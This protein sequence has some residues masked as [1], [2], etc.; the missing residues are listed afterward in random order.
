M[1]V[2]ERIAAAQDMTDELVSMVE[3]DGQVLCSQA[4]PST[5]LALGVSTTR[6]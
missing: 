1:A 5:R 3:P 2:C 4:I 6:G